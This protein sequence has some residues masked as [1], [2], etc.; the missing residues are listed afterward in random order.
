HTLLGLM[1]PLAGFW[2]QAATRGSG[3]R[4]PEEIAQAITDELAKP[5]Y[6]LGNSFWSRVID[7]LQ[8]AWVRF[9]EWAADIS[10]YVGGPLVLALVV[11]GAVIALAVVVTANLGRRRARLVDERIR[12][13][14]ELAR[15]H[16]P[17]EL[18]RRADEAQAQGDHET[19]LRLLFQAGLIRLDRA[20]IIDLRPGTTSGTVAE[21]VGAPEFERLAN[22]FDA[23]VYGDQPASVADGDLAR[24]VMAALLEQ[25]RR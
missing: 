2:Q 3:G 23:V 7:W 4:P 12:R 25:A 20:G 11:G 10:E 6:R 22:R 17:V 24:S 8:R 18:E 21:S 16:D 9:L 1:A 15:G 5:K 13:E 19:A 14:H